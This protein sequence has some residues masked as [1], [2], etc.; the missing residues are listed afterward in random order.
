MCQKN[1]VVSCRSLKAS[2]LFSLAIAILVSG[3]APQPTPTPKAQPQ[4]TPVPTSVPAPTSAP[5][6]VTIDFEYWGFLT[7]MVEANIKRFESQ[8]SGIKVNRKLS[9]GSAYFDK[10]V[11]N[12]QANV[13]MDVIYGDET[14]RAQYVE[15]GWLTPIDGMPGLDEVKKDLFPFALQAMSYKGKMYGLPYFSYAIMAV[16][17]EKMLKDAGVSKP[18]ETLD[19][20]KDACLAIK[21]AGILNYPFMM[22]LGKKQSISYGWYT[23]V[24]GSGGRFFDDAYNPLLPDKDP[25][26]L[27]V[28]EW[29]VD[30]L[31]TWKI[32]DQSALEQDLNT[33]ATIVQAGQAAFCLNADYDVVSFDNAEK[34]KVVGQIKQFL[35]PSLTAAGSHGTMAGCR[36]YFMPASAQHKPE[37]WKLLYYLGAKDA[38]GTYYTGKQWAL[39]AG[40][41]FGVAP[42]YA[43]SE[44]IAA[45]SK[46]YDLDMRKK[47][48]SLA[49]E[50]EGNTKVWFTQWEEFQQEQIQAALLKQKS[51]RDALQAIAD[52][53]IALMKEQS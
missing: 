15:A 25:T 40:L 11:V 4:A 46:S 29:L 41:S 43:D 14:K 44:V 17:N 20:L 2:L 47:Q 6:P 33:V 49:S 21:K 22:N 35:V 38:E 53:W 45:F 30:A 13:P 39:N 19:E 1:R 31:N 12:F 5:A 32:M 24:K 52:K 27:H 28:L 10:L 34:S 3:C 8:N 18:P 36:G 48:E 51:P 37:A 26:A 50:V 16:Y 23:L 42:L 7:E 9:D